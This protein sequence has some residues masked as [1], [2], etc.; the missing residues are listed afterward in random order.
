MYYLICYVGVLF[1]LAQFCFFFPFPAYDPMNVKYREVSTFFWDRYSQELYS[2]RDQPLWSYAIHHFK[3][4]P[5][6]FTTKG[7]TIFG[8]D[9]FE[10]NR[11]MMGF[12]GHAYNEQTDS[13]AEAAA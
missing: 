9:M 4:K 5:L 1:G 6:A 3:I 10:E 11:K 13:D 7:K 8:G 12:G 2:W